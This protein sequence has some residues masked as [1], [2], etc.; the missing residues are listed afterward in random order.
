MDRK[1]PIRPVFISQVRSFWVLEQRWTGPGL[2][3]SI[4]GQK[5]GPDRTY[6]H[7][8]SAYICFIIFPLNQYLNRCSSYRKQQVRFPILLKSTQVS[9]SRGI[10]QS[11][12]FYSHWLPNTFRSFLSLCGISR[13]I[14]TLSMFSSS[15]AQLIKVVRVLPQLLTLLV[16]PIGVWETPC[17]CIMPLGR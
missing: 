14:P 8:L 5:T 16:N 15:R 1:R 12:S 6:K 13:Y 3:P 4:L 7:Y 2:S 17:T 10:S 11:F 9:T